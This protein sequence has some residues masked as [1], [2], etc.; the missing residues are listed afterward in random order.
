[1][2]TLSAPGLETENYGEADDNFLSKSWKQWGAAEP[3]EPRQLYILRVQS[4][5]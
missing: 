2:T 1:V 3:C 5:S 4:D